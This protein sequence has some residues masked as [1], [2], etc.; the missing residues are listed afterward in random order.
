MAEEEMSSDVTPGNAGA[1]A[2]ARS[3]V[4]DAGK[5]DEARTQLAKARDLTPSERL[6]IENFFTEQI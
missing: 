6:E 4:T 3:A 2:Y 1:G 5:K